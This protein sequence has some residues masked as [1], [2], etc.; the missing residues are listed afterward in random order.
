MREYIE[1]I[2]H[3]FSF[4]ENGFKVEEKRALNDYKAHDREYIKALALLAYKSDAYEAL[5]NK[6]ME[7][8]DLKE[9]F[10]WE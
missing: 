5:E 8:Y 2:E 4:I 10:E 1:S 6:I 7:K 3:D 9:P